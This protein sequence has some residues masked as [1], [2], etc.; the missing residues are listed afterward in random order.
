MRDQR[1][2]TMFLHSFFFLFFF[3]YLLCGQLLPLYMKTITNCTQIFKVKNIIFVKTTR[4]RRVPSLHG[5]STHWAL[6]SDLQSSSERQGL[7]CLTQGT[8]LGHAIKGNGTGLVNEYIH[9]CKQQF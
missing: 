3:D 4:A 6:G 7:P 1:H 2:Q 9:K 8:S 5:A